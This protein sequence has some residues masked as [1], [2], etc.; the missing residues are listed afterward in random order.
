MSKALKPS[1][2]ATL[3]QM[4]LQEPLG[5]VLE[6]EGLVLEPIGAVLAVMLLDF[7]ASAMDQVSRPH[8][9]LTQ[10]P[11]NPHSTLT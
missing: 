1:V 9:I 3:Q 11:P 7:E 4:R 8:L 5:E 10:S 2:C 6:G